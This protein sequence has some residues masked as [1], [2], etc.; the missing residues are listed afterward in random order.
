MKK[1]DPSEEAFI[2]K[3]SHSIYVDDVATSLADV[4]A[5]Y[6]FY[7]TARLHLAKVSFK[8]G[9][10]SQELRQKIVGDEQGS[11]REPAREP[12]V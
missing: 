1:M 11:H 10:N 8:F 2:H 9:T 12:A 5:A 4:D 6:Q 3:F 7:L